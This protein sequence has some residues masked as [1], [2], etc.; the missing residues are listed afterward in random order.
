MSKLIRRTLGVMIAIGVGVHVGHVIIMSN[1]DTRL[2]P[3][4]H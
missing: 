3:G 4:R 2:R 1:V